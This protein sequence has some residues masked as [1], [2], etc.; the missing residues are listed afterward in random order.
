MRCRAASLVALLLGVLA[1]LTP[2]AYASPPDPTWIAGLWDDADYDDVVVLVASSSGAIEAH[3]VTNV[4]PLRV[5]SELAPR[6]IPS[7]HDARVTRGR[8]RAPPLV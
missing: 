3:F 7:P 6:P 2:L 8:P 1:L 4:E 5:V